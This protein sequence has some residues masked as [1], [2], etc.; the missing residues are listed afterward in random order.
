MDLKESESIRPPQ[1]SKRPKVADKENE[2]MMANGA[3]NELN[4]SLN[5]FAKTLPKSIHIPRGQNVSQPRNESYLQRGPVNNFNQSA[6]VDNNRSAMPLH[7]SF[8]M[9]CNNTTK[10]GGKCNE[11]QPCDLHRQRDLRYERYQSRNIQS[12]LQ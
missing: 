9:S 3:S 5:N 1:S 10:F 7:D 11:T 6:F 8:N 12:I 4:R 2:Q